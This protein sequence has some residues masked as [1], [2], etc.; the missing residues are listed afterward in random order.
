MKPP[1]MMP[2]CVLKSRVLL[3][4][5]VAAAAAADVVGGKVDVC[6]KVVVNAVVVN[7][8]TICFNFFFRVRAL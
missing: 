3:A 1:A 8:E 4:K 7:D 5:D 2:A 6:V